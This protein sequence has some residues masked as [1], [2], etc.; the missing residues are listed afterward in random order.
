M[1]ASQKFLPL[2][3]LAI[4][5]VG[6]DGLK[7]GPVDISITFAPVFDGTEV[8]YEQSLHQ[9]AT[10][11][12]AFTF[13]RSDL[14]LTDFS[15]LDE[16]G[17]VAN[18]IGGSAA[19]VHM[20]GD[21]S[22]RNWTLTDQIDPGH[23]G[24]IRFYIGPDTSANHGDPS[25]WPAGHPLNPTV[26]GLHW[27]WTAGYIFSALEGTYATSTGTN[28]FLYHIGI[29]SNR[30]RVDILQDIDFRRDR[31]VTV[32]FNL[33]NI[34]DGTHLIEPAITGDFTH[35][36]FDNG[37]ASKVRDNLM[38]AFSIKDIY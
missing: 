35:S 28:Y 7:K 30:V 34:F 33:A 32:D 16:S 1:K 8:V 37:L 27:G 22:D 38:G 13:V 19:Y 5:L 3:S 31:N 25:L 18:E 17:E 15:L 20:A 11:N 6:C 2:L 10:T 4:L 14:I 21:L 12:D 23:Y 29:D 26:N 36:T 9:S 24:G